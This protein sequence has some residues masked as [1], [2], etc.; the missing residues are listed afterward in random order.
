MPDPTPAAY[1]CLEPVLSDWV[2]RV[3]DRQVREWP[4]REAARRIAARRVARAVAGA[5][6]LTVVTGAFVFAIAAFVEG[7]WP[8]PVR[9][10]LLTAVFFSAWPAALVAWAVTRLAASVAIGRRVHAPIRLTGIAGE[11]LLRLA[12]E[13][14]LASARALAT[15]WQR[16]SAALPLAALSMIA[17]LT[18]HFVVWCLVA[19]REALDFGKWIAISVV[20]V[21][22]AHVALGVCSVLWALSLCRRETSALDSRL[23]R[24]WLKALGITVGVACVPG[25][26]LLGIPPLLVAV[27]G[28]VF[29]PAMF[30]VTVRCMRR[31]RL[32]LET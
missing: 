22:H 6:G 20:V 2:E 21:G 23:L 24:G 14:S 1:R 28:L 13:D 32:A 19:P 15:R 5:T 10:W 3:H 17:P 7:S 31:E 18:L 26:L 30:A 4:E 8:A 29:V 25:V 11:D 9:E 16:A 12:H 27:T